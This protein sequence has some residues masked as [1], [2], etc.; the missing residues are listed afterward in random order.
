MTLADIA[1]AVRSGDGHGI[2]GTDLAATVVT[3]EVVIDSRAAGP[4]D[5]FIALRGERTDGHDHAGEAVAR[6]AIAVLAERDL[7]LDVPV[8]VVPETLVAL[9]SLARQVF[10]LDQPL[11][12]GLTGSSGKTSTK[13]LLA[14]VLAAFGSTLA[15]A[16]SFNNEIGLPLTATQR[17]SETMYAA[18][19]YSARGIGHIAFLC[20]I[21]RPHVAI[22][23]NVGS[24]HL[25]EFGSVENIAVAKGELVEAAT[26]LAV[27]NADD[28]LV[29][30]M[31]ARTVHPVVTFGRSQ[32]AEYRASEISV[33]DDGRPSFRL[34]TPKGR[35]PVQLQVRGEHQVWNALAVAAAVIGAGVTSDVALVARHLGEARPVSRWRMEVTERPDGVT[36]VNDAYN[37]NPDSML[38]AL[39]TLAVM[40]RD[41]SRRTWAVL[42]PMAELGPD[43]ESAHVEVGRAARHLAVS[44]L[45]VIGSAAAGIHAGA[46]AE[47]AGAGELAQ[48][49]DIDAAVALLRAELRPGDVVLVKASRSVGLERVAAALLAGAS[50]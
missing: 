31:A 35:A 15:P 2:V 7:P 12:F 4:G 18:L 23:L 25:G 42:G 30:A 32:D 27:L 24:A 34:E 26:S 17:T 46:V 1:S 19:E 16:E 21:V 49:D 48:V 14:Q 29:S 37:A 43:A 10:S 40:G 6:G 39:R 47:G 13:D 50:E 11:T 41:G 3:G 38:A 22:V 45:V 8:F 33:D 44:R 20:D 9:Q 36:V 5:L 28:P